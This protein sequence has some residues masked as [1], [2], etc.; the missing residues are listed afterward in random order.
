MLLYHFTSRAHL[1]SIR[2]SGL[3]RGEVHVARDRQLNA[4]WL[5]ADGNSR[6][7]GLETGGAFM[8][9]LDRREA[10]KWTGKV[11]PEGSRLPK[12]ADVRIAVE[13]DSADRNLHEWLPWARRH[14]DLEWLAQLQP[15]ASFNLKKAKAWRIYTGII[16]PEAF[17][18]VEELEAEP[19]PVRPR[20]ALGG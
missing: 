7:H 9:E 11:P 4:V 14:L 15:V 19:E 5:T 6:G 13:I 12:P 18:A 17:V 1:R 20:L 2:A 10:S 16:P 8:T 3:T